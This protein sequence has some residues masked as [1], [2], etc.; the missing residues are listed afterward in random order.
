M[1]HGIEIIDPGDAGGGFEPLSPLPRDD[2]DR[3]PYN[4]IPEVRPA[5]HQRMSSLSIHDTKPNTKVRRDSAL[6]QDGFA[7][8]RLAKE[9]EDWGA[10]YRRKLI[11]PQVEIEKMAKKAKGSVLAETTRMGAL[12]SQHLTRLVDD[13]NAEERGD[14]RWEPVYI[15]SSKI[16]RRTGRIEC[17][18]MDVIVARRKPSPKPGKKYR[19]SSGGELVDIISEGKSK[20][21]KKDK[22]KDKDGDKSSSPKR[23]SFIDDPFSNQPLFHKT[24]MPMDD[25]GILDF[26][27]GGLPAEIPADRPIGF[28][29]REAQDDKKGKKRGSSQQGDDD[30]IL[31]VNDVEP[32]SAAV[33]SI[34]AILGRET[35]HDVPVSEPGRRSRSRR[36]SRGSRPRSAGRP[37]SISFPPS[38]H[39]R[40]YMGDLRDSSSNSS[41]ESR[42]GIDREE[43]SSYTSDT[44]SGIGRRGSHFDEG[45]PKVYKEHH[46]GPS[47]SGA[48]Y[49]G[50][51]RVYEEPARSRRRFSRGSFSQPDR[52]PEAR[53]IG[54]KDYGG[55]LV[56]RPYDDPEPYYPP[57]RGRAVPP[58]SPI[59]HYPNEI[60][61]ERYMDEAVRDDYVS[62]REREIRDRE[63]R[64]DALEQREEEI[65]R[66]EDRLQRELEAEARH[67]EELD[68]RHYEHERRMRATADRRYYDDRYGGGYYGRYDE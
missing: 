16:T 27:N 64:M 47:R 51:A 42:Y 68:R 21:D 3:I 52:I 56:R 48:N 37:E 46:R 25:R 44:Y 53:Q 17:K 58:M 14:E 10:A 28:D 65:R 62:R 31:D 8:W 49:Y 60:P 38:Y 54:Y 39:T 5:M 50:D 23:D 24:G 18:S 55:D 13:L 36:R 45:R 20:G 6:G 32:A 57:P 59:L 19:S 41:N 43:R 26:K 4:D 29:A 33:D 35:S 66:A 1:S 2:L 34:D 67:Q 12:R 63:L 11:A 61:A 22:K 9:G 15:K 40:Q 30:L 7:Y